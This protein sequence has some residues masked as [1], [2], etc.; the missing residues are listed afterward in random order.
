MFLT[1]TGAVLLAAAFAAEAQQAGNYDRL[2][3]LA[4]ELVRLK[5]DVIVGA[6]HAARAAKNATKTIPIVMTTPDPVGS[7][8]M[9]PGRQART[10]RP[11]ISINPPSEDT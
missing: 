7:G 8:M 5:V 3:D 10:A 2:A 9:P 6:I 11:S 4:A 1:G